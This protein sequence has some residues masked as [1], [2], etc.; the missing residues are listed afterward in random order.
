MGEE[1]DEE[2]VAPGEPLGVGELEGLGLGEAVVV[3]VVVAVVAAVGCAVGEE[4][5]G[6]VAVGVVVAVAVG[7]AMGVAMGVAVGVAVGP[8]GA[9]LTVAALRST[10]FDASCTSITPSLLD[11]QIPEPGVAVVEEPEDEDVVAR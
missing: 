10:E 11:A 4:A 9:P 3:A 5:G 8:T 7:D 2:D 1:A 6:G